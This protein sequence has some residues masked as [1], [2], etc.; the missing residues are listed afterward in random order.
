MTKKREGIILYTDLLNDYRSDYLELENLKNGEEC[1]ID[2][3]VFGAIITGKVD[4]W[5]IFL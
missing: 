5:R 4:K 2:S 1:F 3:V